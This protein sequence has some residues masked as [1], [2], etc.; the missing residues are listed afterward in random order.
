[1]VTREYDLRRAAEAAQ[2]RTKKERAAEALRQSEQ[3]FSVIFDKAA[4]AIALQN[5]PEGIIVDVN[6]AWEK[7][8][9]FSRAE[10]LGKTSVELGINRDISRRSQFFSQAIEHGSLSNQ[11]TI[12]FSKAGHPRLISYNTEVVRIGSDRHFLSTMRDITDQREAEQAL[13]ASEERFRSIFEVGLIGMAITSP[14]KGCIEVNDKLCRILGYER[15]ELLRKTWAEMTHPDDLGADVA[16]FNRVIAG[17]TDGYT[18]DK[19]WIRKDGRIVDSIMAAQCVRRDDGSVDYFVGLVQDVTA[20]KLAEEEHRKLASL[21]ENSSDF[22]G[23]AS[24][25]GEVLFVNDAGKKLVGF[26]G[27]G[28]STIFD[29][30]TEEN[31]TFVAETLL[32]QIAREGAWEGEMP[33]RHFQTAAEIPMHVNVF[34]IREEGT[35]RPLALATISRD[36]TERKEGEKKL[37]ESGRRF[38]LLAESI[39]H[40]VWSFRVDGSLGYWNQR[41]TDYTGLNDNELRSGGWAALHPEDIEPARSAWRKAFAKGAPYDMEHRIRGANGHYRRFVCRAMPVRDQSGNTLEWFGTNT[42]VEERR[43]SEE[44]L[45]QVQAELAH[46]T[47]MSTLGEIAASIAHEINQPLGAIVNNGNVCLKL[48]NTPGSEKKKR[49][50]LLDIVN[51]AIRA[52]AIITRIRALTKRSILEKKSFLVDELIAEVLALAHQAANKAGV[53]MKNLVPARLRVRG[54]R[55]QLQQMLL[56]LVMNGIQAMTAVAKSRRTMTI[57]AERDK[58]GG[59]SAMTISVQDSGP[60]I[61]GIDADRLFEP[62]FTTKSDGMGLGLAISRSIAEAHNGRLWAEQN[63][64]PGATFYCALPSGTAK[65]RS[66]RK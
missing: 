5:F 35:G 12:F 30:M 13:R 62:F 22:I 61:G 32:P 52:S 6:Q 44:K 53:S 51:D 2:P 8:F 15:D 23:L 39:P 21:V 19:R 4:S 63:S 36:I 49:E 9:G 34:L 66:P 60:G 50:A 10:V 59:K 7:I 3:K 17:E 26:N 56:N 33:M 27:Q 37:Q 58:L 16:Q 38:R 11:E 25:E 31:G 1:E 57:R 45:Q 18:L 64:G 46:V 40:Q 48:M 24:L 43:Q 20:R 28:A 47:R 41:L 14:A 42:D 29:Y 65:L 55:I 54:D